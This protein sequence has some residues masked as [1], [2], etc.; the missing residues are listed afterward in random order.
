MVLNGQKKNDLSKF[1]EKFVKN[2]GEN[3]DKGYIL[4]VTI[5]YPEILHDKHKDLPFLP[6][7][8]WLINVKN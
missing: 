3:S 7:K 2:C 8:K 1:D 5:M 6:D 4:E